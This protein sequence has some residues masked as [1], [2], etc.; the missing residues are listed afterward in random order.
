MV[1][2]LTF[3][4]ASSP[5]QVFKELET[6]FLDLDED[7][8][9]ALEPGELAQCV[10]LI[11]RALGIARTSKVILDDVKKLMKVCDAD[12]SGALEF[13]EFIGH[14]YS[15]S[16]NGTP[17]LMFCLILKACLR[18]PTSSRVSAML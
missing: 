10:K 6:L 7:H 5:V 17:S 9:G 11:Y 13:F 3:N 12:K 2:A 18:G 8:S 15:A 14:L 16:D 1:T 4:G